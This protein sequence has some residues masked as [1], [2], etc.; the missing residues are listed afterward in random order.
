MQKMLAWP[1]YFSSR[2]IAS[3]PFS[4]LRPIPAFI[5]TL[6]SAYS[7]SMRSEAAQSEDGIID[8]DRSGSYLSTALRANDGV[9]PL[10]S[11][12]HPFECK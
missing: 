9:V 8:V 12:W 1:L 7:A 10:F 4:S 3:F 6:A 2:T 5:G 11:Q